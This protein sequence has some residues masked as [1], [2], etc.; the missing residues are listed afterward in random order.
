MNQV[1]P[2]LSQLLDLFSGC[3]RQEAFQTFR[4]MVA[5][6]VVCPG[7]RTLSEVWQATGL[8]GRVHHDRAYS[9]FASARWSWDDLGRVLLPLLVAR[10]VPD[11]PVWLV[12]DDTLC[13]KRGAKVALG[14]FFLDP[15]CSSRK[16]KTFRFGVNWVVLGLVVRLPFRP[17]RYVCLP[18]L[19]RAYRKAGTPGH[20]KRTELAAEM[21]RLAAGWLAR[22]EC[23]LVGDSAYVNATTLKGRPANLGVV[24]PLRPDAALYAPPPARPPGR[25]GA[26]RKRG[27]RLMTPAQAFA[28]ASAYPAAEC[29]VDLPGGPKRVRTQVMAGVLWYAGA[30]EERVTVVLV[31]D[32]S[33]GWK[34]AA[35]LVSAPSAS[36]EFAVAGYCRRWS[37]EVAFRDS[38]QHLGLHDAHVRRE[39]SVERAHPAA[40]FASSL[41]V[42]WYAQAGRDGEE[43]RR[44][45]PWYA[46][47]VGITF[48]DML[49][50]LRLEQWRAR[51]RGMSQ[52]GMGHK[53]IIET[54]IQWNAA[55]R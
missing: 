47:K 12:V 37:I 23:W 45:R 15:V 14:G 54:L 18:V 42:L 1:S 29:E 27:E 26:P 35:L 44:E 7:P 2:A 25:R 11:G 20:R 22:R 48:A 38:K 8:A 51:I 39:S 16:R 32:P 50:A 24:G 36:A 5:A 3:F 33:G 31:R 6:W 9:L 34:D 55:V 10:L 28:D 17:D 40:W 46:H 21:A 41:T 53:E 19:W 43:V 30:G 4:L 52:A 13:H 49:G